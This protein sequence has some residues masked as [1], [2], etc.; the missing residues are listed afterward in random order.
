[1]CSVSQNKSTKLQALDG[2]KAWTT[3]KTY[4]YELGRFDCSGYYDEKEQNNYHR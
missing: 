3:V 1:M 2:K 4:H